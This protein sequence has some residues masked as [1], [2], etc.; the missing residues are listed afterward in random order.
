MNP[1]PTPGR[2]GLRIAKPTL[3]TSRVQFSLL[4]NVPLFYYDMHMNVQGGYLLFG[5]RLADRSGYTQ[6][7]SFFG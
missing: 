3:L 5:Y 6:M 7:F 2:S 1:S 4:Y